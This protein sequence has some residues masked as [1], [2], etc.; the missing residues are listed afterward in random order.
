MQI[1]LSPVFQLFS[2]QESIIKEDVADE[3]APQKHIVD[4]AKAAQA[5]GKDYS[6]AW[7]QDEEGNDAVATTSELVRFFDVHG[8][9][10]P[11]TRATCAKVYFFVLRS[12]EQIFRPQMK[13][14]LTEWPPSSTLRRRLFGACTQANAGSCL[15]SVTAVNGNASHT[16]SPKLGSI[17]VASRLDATSSQ[18][19]SLS[20]SEHSLPA[21]ISKADIERYYHLANRGESLEPNQAVLL[22]K[23][24]AEFGMVEQ[25]RILLR[26]AKVRTAKVRDLE[27]YL[28]GGVIPKGADGPFSISA[29]G[30]CFLKAGDMQGAEACIKERCVQQSK[31]LLI[32]EFRL[33]YYGAIRSKMA[34]KIE[35]KAILKACS[36]EK[37]PSVVAWYV[38]IYIGT[39]I[40]DDL[41]DLI[42]AFVER[43]PNESAIAKQIFEKLATADANKGTEKYVQAQELLAKYILL[44]EPQNP[45]INY[46]LAERKRILQG[47]NTEIKAHYSHALYSKK[48]EISR[49]AENELTILAFKEAVTQEQL[50]ALGSRMRKM[51]KRNHTLPRALSVYGEWLVRC[52]KIE[53]VVAFLE[54]LT[55]SAEKKNAAKK[56][57]AEHIAQ[58]LQKTYPEEKLSYKWASLC[59]AG[60]AEQNL[61]IAKKA[62]EFYP[63]Q[64]NRDFLVYLTDQQRSEK[65][66]KSDDDLSDDIPF[67]QTIRQAKT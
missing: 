8:F 67:M 10:T 43:C 16:A 29:R 27:Y 37:L 14:P 58:L 33:T 17:A 63:T 23:E 6:I 42:T 52:K 13:E 50:E 36:K 21:V 55:K 61:V 20:G 54:E 64:E 57:V 9:V 66:K 48:V 40:D 46:F 53:D 30:I 47:N 3:C 25:S 28:I 7:I 38:Q 11:Q 45:E 44:T 62:Y 41:V 31:E 34:F 5:Q 26:A 32:R 1:D 35:E 59:F 65:S 49:Y 24:A 19:T 15:R 4:Q 18:E 2:A 51:K 39:E 60:T 22:A 12:S 56:K